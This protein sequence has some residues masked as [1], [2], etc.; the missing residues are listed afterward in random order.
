MGLY[1]PSDHP[2]RCRKV[3]FSIWYIGFLFIS[4][5]PCLYD[6][7][8]RLVDPVDD[9]YH[10]WAEGFFMTP[11]VSWIHPITTVLGIRAFFVQAREIR[12]ASNSGLQALSM[13]GLAVQAGVFTLVAISWTMRIPYPDDF[14]DL[15]FWLMA[16]YWYAMIGWAAVDNAVFAAVQCRLFL[17]ARRRTL[18]P[19]TDGEVEPLLGERFDR[20]EREDQ[21]I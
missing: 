6:V 11:H 8:D 20:T 15:P 10:K 12:S 3:S 18:H 7:I 9:P 17:L 1:Y 4:L 2:N 13:T 14:V 19:V 5:V 21:A 16:F